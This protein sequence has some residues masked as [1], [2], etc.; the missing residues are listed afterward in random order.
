MPELKTYDSF[1]SHAWRYHSDYDR[2]VEMLKKA[3]SFSFRNYNV[4]R[5]DPAIDPNTQAGAA[6]LSS[7]LV[8]QIR[9]TNC[10]LILAGMYAAHSDWIQREIRLAQDDHKPIV[11]VRP[12]GQARTP[13]SVESAAREMVGWNT[14]SIVGAVRRHAI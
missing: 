11:G 7:E 13:V 1:I 10:V 9:P 2:I 8:K 4:P 6:R 14:A 3:P 12:W 5:H